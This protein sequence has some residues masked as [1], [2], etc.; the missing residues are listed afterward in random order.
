MSYLKFTKIEVIKDAMFLLK[1]VS[2]LKK[3]EWGHNYTLTHKQPSDQ[4]R[5]YNFS[6]MK[7]N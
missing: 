4:S 3:L 7:R 6:R 1:F 2:Q 5:A